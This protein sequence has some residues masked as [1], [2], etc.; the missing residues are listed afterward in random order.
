MYTWTNSWKTHSFQHTPV[1]SEEGSIHPTELSKDKS[2]NCARRDNESK[3]KCFIVRSNFCPLLTLMTQDTGVS[4]I[5]AMRMTCAMS[6]RARSFSQ[7]REVRKT[8]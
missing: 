6:P 7:R 1:E 8:M 4:G 5:C 2:Q 3:Q